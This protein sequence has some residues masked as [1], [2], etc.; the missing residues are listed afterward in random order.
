MRSGHCWRS[1]GSTIRLASK[2]ASAFCRGDIVTKAIPIENIYYLLS[3]AWDVLEERELANVTVEGT[4]RLQDLLARVLVGGVTHLLKR[5]LDR[6]YLSREEEIA[7][8]RGRLLVGRS[9]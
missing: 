6:T 9:I 3:Y 4:M 7:G 2:N 5:G 8:V 1:T